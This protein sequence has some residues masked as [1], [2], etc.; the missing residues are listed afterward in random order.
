MRALIII[1]PLLLISC[2]QK[3]S[4]QRLS[5]IARDFYEIPNFFKIQITALEVM[6]EV[7]DQDYSCFEYKVDINLKAK[8]DLLTLRP[9]RPFGNYRIRTTNGEKYIPITN[10]KKEV[11][12]EM[13]YHENQI[14][15]VSIIKK[16]IRMRGKKCVR[17]R[18]VR[19]SRAHKEKIIGR[20]IA[21]TKKLFPFAINKDQNTVVKELP[22]VVCQNGLTQKWE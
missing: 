21:S 4:Q 8:E 17:Y 18:R 9:V 20:K 13:K 10:T 3:P 19:A 14:H 12:K 2:N 6:S 16:C 7:V 15:K 1:I 11:E 22:L 5:E